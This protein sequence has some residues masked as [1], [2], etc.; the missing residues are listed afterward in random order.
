MTT[1]Y[2]EADGGHTHTVF[3]CACYNMATTVARIE[4]YFATRY[5]IF[6]GVTVY[7]CCHQHHYH[8]K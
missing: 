7:C 8:K 2:F 3:F 5:L 1:M 4:Q 6:K